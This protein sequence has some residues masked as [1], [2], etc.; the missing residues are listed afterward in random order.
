MRGAARERRRGDDLGV[1]KSLFKRA[2]LKI[3]ALS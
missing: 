1:E 2:I 3:L